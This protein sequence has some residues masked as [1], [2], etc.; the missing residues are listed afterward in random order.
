MRDQA[1][2][3]QPFKRENMGKKSAQIQPFLVQHYNRMEKLRPIEQRGNVQ[4]QTKAI[5]KKR[6]RCCLLVE[7][8]STMKS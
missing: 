5:E 2:R 3:R 1:N 6:L 7:V 8:V 4:W